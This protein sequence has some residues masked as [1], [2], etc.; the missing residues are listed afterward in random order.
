MSIRNTSG[1]CVGI[2][3]LVLALGFVTGCGDDNQLTATD[4]TPPAAPSDLRASSNY[5]DIFL[6]WNANDEADLAGYNVYAAVDGG[7][8][9][10]VAIVPPTS[11]IYSEPC[12]RGHE[13]SY[14]ITAIDQSANESASSTLVRVMHD[15][16]PGGGVRDL[17]SE[18]LTER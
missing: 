7:A 17:I 5:S 14:E 11:T 13:Y 18:G 8:L 10:L 15:G 9:E 12:E 2:L 1:T 4:L 16:Q 6:R 3:F